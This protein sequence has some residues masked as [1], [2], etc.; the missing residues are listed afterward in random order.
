M[1]TH[2]TQQTRLPRKQLISVVKGDQPSTP[3]HSHIIRPQQWK[4]STDKSRAGWKTWTGRCGSQGCAQRVNLWTQRKGTRS[5]TINDDGIHDRNGGPGMDNHGA[6]R[7]IENKKPTHRTHVGH[8]RAGLCAT[9]QSD[10]PPPCGHPAKYSTGPGIHVCHHC[11][12]K[13]SE[14]AELALKTLL[15][16]NANPPL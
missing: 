15:M 6:T 5:P 3:S 11:S 12:R 9:P 10:L 13:P 8:S 7:I 14:T 16:C 4:R 1:K 2:C